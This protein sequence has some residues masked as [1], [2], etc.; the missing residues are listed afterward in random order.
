MDPATDEADEPAGEPPAP[1]RPRLDKRTVTICV[2]IAAVAA[3]V[4]AVIVTMLLSDDGSSTAGPTSSTLLPAKQAPETT[5]FTRFDGSPVELSDYKGQKLV[6]NFF[7]STCVPC[8]K[9]MPALQKVHQRLGDDVTFIGIAVQ[10]DPKAAQ[11]LIKKTGVTY[12]LAQ[13]RTG[14]LFQRFGATFLPTTAFVDEEGT[15]M[16]LHTGA[17][18]EAKITQLISSNLLAGG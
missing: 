16:E 10:D 15:V 14:T 12:D 9:E 6:V 17:M 5:A 13:D 1:R 7:A 4:A 2:V 11:Q 18:D 8:K 3:V